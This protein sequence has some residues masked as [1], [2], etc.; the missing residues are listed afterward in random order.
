MACQEK[1]KAWF[2]VIDT[3]WCAIYPTK[4]AIHSGCFVSARIRTEMTFS[5]DTFPT[6]ALKALYY[7]PND[8]SPD[9]IHIVF[10]HLPDLLLTDFHSLSL[11]SN[12]IS[13]IKHSINS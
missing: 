9:L 10:Y 13:L 7:S 5:S 12:I 1:D 11:N 8:S 3:P 2:N 6:I 4:Q